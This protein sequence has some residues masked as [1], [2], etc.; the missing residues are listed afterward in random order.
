[1][2][3]RRNKGAAD[4]PATMGTFQVYEELDFLTPPECEA[5]IARIDRGKAASSIFSNSDA[6]NA[7]F[8][9]NET[10]WL[11][12]AD[13]VVRSLFGRL[14]ALLGVEPSHGEAMQGQRY[15]VGGRFK[16]HHDYFL[17]D[18]PYWQ[19]EK[20][21]GGQRTWTAMIFLNEPAR[22]GRT[23]FPIAGL[24]F[25]PRTGTLLFWNN[26]AA[27][28]TPDETSL[29][30]GQPVEAGAKYIVTQWFRER[31][32]LKPGIVAAFRRRLY[33]LASRVRKVVGDTVSS[34]PRK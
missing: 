25:T 22:G 19:V 24:S 33:R 28:G 15:S 1:M 14:A 8:R 32:C 27:D 23:C 3:S 4:S 34:R 31:P 16:P 12:R 29:H 26:L 9:T 20:R 11:S 10:C 21:Q 13:P 2:P 5:L 18:R 30:E 17:T 7:D 6:P